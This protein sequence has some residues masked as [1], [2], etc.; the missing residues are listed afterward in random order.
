MFWIALAESFISVS[1]LDPDL[2]I[3]DMGGLLD[4]NPGDTKADMKPVPVP[5]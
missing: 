3:R 5:T 4:P 2:P 1:D